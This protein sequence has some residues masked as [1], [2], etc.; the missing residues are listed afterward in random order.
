[1]SYSQGGGVGWG[2]QGTETET[3]VEEPREISTHSPDNSAMWRSGTRI[4]RSGFLR[5]GM[6]T[7][8]SMNLTLLNTQL[9]LK[10][11]LQQYTWLS[12]LCRK[13]S[14]KARRHLDSWTI[15]NGFVV[16]S[17]QEKDWNIRDKKE[18]KKH[19]DGPMKVG[20]SVK[21]FELYFNAHQRASPRKIH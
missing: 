20:T 21:I 17:G 6:G 9:P 2:R 3:R 8:G 11:A 1:M 16:S 4:R 15:T 14:V 12:A 5:H 7:S 10:S 13:K 18:G 19:V